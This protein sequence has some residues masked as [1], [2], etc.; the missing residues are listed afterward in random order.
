MRFIDV[1]RNRFADP[2][3]RPGSNRSCRPGLG[4]AGQFGQRWRRL[5]AVTRRRALPDVLL[6]SVV[7]Q[8]TVDQDHV[9][10]VSSEVQG[11]ARF[12]RCCQSVS[13]YD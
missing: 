6:L 2:R 7:A 10:C 12:R 13:H 8:S 5:A 1:C 3:Y 9:L 11:D 4:A